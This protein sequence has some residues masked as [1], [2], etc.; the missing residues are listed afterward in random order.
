M[1]LTIAARDSQGNTRGLLGVLH[2]EQT[3]R[4][5][6]GSL[7][8]FDLDTSTHWRVVNEVSA[9]ASFGAPMRIRIRELESAAT[10]TWPAEHRLTL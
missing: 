5:R 6:D 1:R 8:T 9:K 2:E 4:R 3:I 7:A 10:T